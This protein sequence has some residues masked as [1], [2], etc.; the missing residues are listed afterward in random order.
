M[1]HTGSDKGYLKN[2]LMIQLRVF[3]TCQE[4]L[5]YF[6]RT[7]KNNGDGSWQVLLPKKNN[8]DGS[9]Q[10][11]SLQCRRITLITVLLVLF[12]G[13]MD[14]QSV[15]QRYTYSHP[16]MGTVFKLIFYT[17]KD[18]SFANALAE[19]VFARVDTLNGVYSD[20]LPESELSRLSDMAGSGKKIK[21]SDDL[22]Q[23]LRLSK[24]FSR[25]SNGSFDIT[26][27]ALTRLWRK[28][29]NMKELPDSV[30]IQAALATVGSEF[31]HCSSGQQVQLEKKGT[32]L[33]LG[34]IAQGFAADECLHILKKASVFRA[35]ADAGGDIALGEAPPGTEGWSIERATGL[36]A[37][38]ATEILMLANC[39]ITTSGAQYR[40][41][42]S[43][44]TRYS[45]I[46]D[47]RTGWGMTHRNL[48]T[49][50]APNAVTAD[51]WATALSVM[52][53]QEWLT[54]RPKHKDLTV[55]IA[56]MPL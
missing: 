23:I 45:H 37:P 55:W 34:G 7:A 46:V 33:D 42:E 27:G 21:V 24:G 12:F 5:P 48:V 2:A 26:V 4:A 35:L 22:W 41:F 51:A 50:K 25:V 31:I 54:L 36:A 13:K 1:C 30:R 39:G 52:S 18:S 56:V 9:W 16:Q 10:I 3:P 40:Y 8:G 49:I 44:G 38:A 20:Y 14:A 53:E 28:A 11:F 6:S 47:P 43:G 19:R 29:R 15:E 17:D 32:R